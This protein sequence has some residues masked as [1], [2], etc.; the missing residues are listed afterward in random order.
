VVRGCDEILRKDPQNKSAKKL[1]WMAKKR[2]KHHEVKMG[3]AVMS[4]ALMAVVGSM[5]FMNKRILG[6]L[7][8]KDIQVNS[9][10]EELGDLR[11]ENLLLYRKLENNFQDL[12][13]VKTSVLDLEKILPEEA[14]TL[15]SK[16]DDARDELASKSE[17]VEKLV[18][19]G[20]DHTPTSLIASGDTLDVL[21]LGTHGRLT[22]T[23]LLASINPLE[24]TVSL[25]SIPR[26]LAINGRRINE[27]YARFG[28]DAMRTQI[29]EITGL[30]PEKYV[31]V[32][33]EAFSSVVDTLGGIDVDVP[34]ALYDVNYPAPNFKYQTFSVEAGSHHFNGSTALKYARS[35]K[36]T[37]DFD[38]AARQQLII[39]AVYDKIKSLDLLENMDEL[40]GLAS[41][42]IEQL[43]TDVDLLDFVV[44]SKRFKDFEIERGNVL[45]TGNYLYSMI[46]PQGA[47][48]LLPKDG[49]YA[50]IRTYVAKEVRG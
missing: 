1:K 18:L 9:L 27:Y 28:I 2:L 50:E 37:S 20:V 41:E 16:L 19:A 14:L 42:V 10:I 33:L 29:E 22:D 30:Y 40:V 32:D 26:D 43:E 23:I 39:E 12:N 4:M 31:V 21:I 36:S 6:D 45:S 17:A 11:E 24:E 48:L 8:T 34:R 15:Q 5:S 46:S 49:T 47:Y 38:R 35:R 7:Q 44:Y 3:V 25:F 13:V